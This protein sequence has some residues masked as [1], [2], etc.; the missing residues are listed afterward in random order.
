MCFGGE[1]AA[2]R[3]VLETGFSERPAAPGKVL[4]VPAA[5]GRERDAVARGMDLPAVAEVERHVV[6]LGGLGASSSGPEEEEIGGH[7]AFDLDSPAPRHFTGHRS[8][9][10]ST[11]GIREL[12]CARVGLELVDPPREARAVEATSCLHTE[13]RL[14]QFALAAPD[15]READEADGGREDA[16]LPGGEDGKLEACSRFLDALLVPVRQPEDPGGGI[17]G[18]GARSGIREHALEVVL[19]CR[20][21]RSETE[22]ASYDLGAEASRRSQTGRCSCP[23][24]ARGLIAEA[25]RANESRVELGHGHRRAGSRGRLRGRRGG[26]LTQADR[27]VAQLALCERIV[28]A[29]C[30]NARGH[31]AAGNDRSDLGLRPGALRAR[32]SGAGC[33]RQAGEQA[34]KE[35]EKAQTS[36]AGS[37]RRFSQTPLVCKELWWK[38]P[39]SRA[40]QSA[41]ACSRCL[42]A[43]AERPRG[44]MAVCGGWPGCSR[45]LNPTSPRRSGPPPRERRGA[46]PAPAG[47]RSPEIRLSASATPSPTGDRC[48]EST[49]GS[50]AAESGGNGL[51]PRL[52]A[53]EIASLRYDSSGTIAVRAK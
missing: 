17:G 1:N 23:R 12:R 48:V 44:L 37:H 36:H 42:R 45:A 29:K 47:H 9:G 38:S 43:G 15:V 3:A 46:A 24:E 19:T 41:K 52:Q 8:G 27:E 11:Q 40:P 51:R 4:F 13:G 5:D 50:E 20:V 7:E 22:E 34:R 26:F 21:I 53:A 10:T 39:P 49:G 16:S 18:L 14:G 2:R 25:Q 6:D 32:R 35:G 31:Q 30:R 33:S 28:W